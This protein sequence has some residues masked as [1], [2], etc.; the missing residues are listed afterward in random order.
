MLEYF[1]DF[2]TMHIV[3]VHVPSNR[4]VAVA[5]RYSVWLALVASRSLVVVVPSM[6]E[7]E[8]RHGA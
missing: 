6:M 4:R 5:I 3:S 8:A 7:T 1:P 2:T